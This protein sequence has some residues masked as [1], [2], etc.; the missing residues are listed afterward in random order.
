LSSSKTE[1]RRSP[2]P[3]PLSA[4]VGN[5]QVVESLES[6]AD[7]VAEVMARMRQ[8]ERRLSLNSFVAYILFTVLLGGGFALL[9]QSRVGGLVRARDAAIGERDAARERAEELQN[10]I[11]KRDA[12][13]Q[14]AYE[15]YSLIRDKRRTEVIAQF[16]KV[17]QLDLTPAEREFF[18]AGVARARSEMVDAGYLAGLDAFRRS[19][20]V[21]AIAEFERALTYEVEGQQ[22]AL[23]RYYMGVAQR[24]SGDSE[25]AI[26]N[27]ELALAGQ[28]DEA[29]VSDARYQLAA[30]FEAI[31]SLDEARKEYSKFASSTPRSP[32]APAARRKVGVL[33]R[34]IALANRAAAPAPA[35]TRPPAPKPG[36]TPNAAPAKPKPTPA[37]PAPAKPKPKPAAAAKPAPAK[38][39]EPFAT[40]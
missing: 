32:L 8:G 2:S 33:A 26:R 7:S 28:V 11:G 20:F 16:P 31:G 6:L 23:M 37:K 9:Y 39:A 30:A 4:Q 21:R 35:G 18:T 25:A 10:A 3:E 13:A 34:K 38:P 14:A 5:H 29:G 24:K 15:Y 1:A 17:E 40:E 27:L 22:A 12:A 19:D 36:Q